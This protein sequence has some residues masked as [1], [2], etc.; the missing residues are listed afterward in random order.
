MGE[1]HLSVVIPCYNEETRLPRTLQE[2]INYLAS[3]PYKSEIVVVSDGSIDATVESAR[4]I[5]FYTPENIVGRVIEYHPNHG[6][7]YAVRTGMMAAKGEHVLFM[8]ADYAVPMR[9]LEP[10]EALLAAGT[11][12]AIGSRAIA[13]TQILRSQGFFRQNIAKVFGLA[14]RTYLGLRFKDTQCGFKLFTRKAARE[15]F[16][17]ALLDSVIFDGEVLWLAKRLGFTAKDFPVEWTHDED[18][19]IAYTPIKALKVSLE[20]LKVPFLHK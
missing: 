4:G 12:I 6:K 19:R 8:D 11:D 18:T 5:F 13:G 1:P 7:G 10:A 15:V 9:Y 14:Q 17:R 2:T 20:V 3:Q 16:S